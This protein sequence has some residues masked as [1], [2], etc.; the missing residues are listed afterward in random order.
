MGIQNSSSYEFQIRRQTIKNIGQQL[1]QLAVDGAGLTPWAAEIL[2]EMTEDI[3]FSN[4]ELR[5]LKHGQVKFCCVAASE[6]PGKT[7]AECKMVTVVL[8]LFDNE[9]RS[10]LAVVGCKQ[11]QI[12]LRQRKLLRIADEAKDQGGL[13]S[14]EDIAELLMCDVKTIQRDVKEFKEK[15]IVIPTRGQQKDIGP[16]VTHRVL[17]IQHWIDGKEPIEV[18]TQTK[19]SLGAVERYLEKFKIIVFL[20]RDKQFNNHEI[21]VVSGISK[22]GVKAFLDIYD[23]RKNHPFFK[24]RL[25]EIMLKGRQYYEETGEKKDCALLSTLNRG[26]KAL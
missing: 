23:E 22:A 9:D 6:G 18:A 16:G 11:R 3:Y 13:L 2:V 1:K 5:D 7:L 14:Q 17:V 24:H 4:T 26:S 8:S 21:S 19:H 15:G 20:R 10:D 25:D 12:F